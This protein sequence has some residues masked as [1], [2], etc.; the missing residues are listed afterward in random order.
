MLRI[1][2]KAS[3]ITRSRTTPVWSRTGMYSWSLSSCASGNSSFACR[4]RPLKPDAEKDNQM[5]V[6]PR[7]RHV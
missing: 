1:R 3:S 7:S 5:G 2:L 6:M 4:T